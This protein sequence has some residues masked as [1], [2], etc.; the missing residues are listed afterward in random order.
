MSSLKAVYLK[1]KA[2][3]KTRRA[4]TIFRGYIDTSVKTFPEG[5][6]IKEIKQQTFPSAAWKKFEKFEGAR[7]NPQYLSR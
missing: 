3:Q 6:Y 5:K 2:V 1:K 7:A 4:A